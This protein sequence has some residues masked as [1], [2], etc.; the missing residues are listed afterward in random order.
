MDFL[1][2]LVLEILA[3]VLG[4]FIADLGLRSL[5]EALRGESSSSPG[6]ALLGYALFGVA[7]GGLSL[8]VLPEPLVHRESLRLAAL[9]IGPLVGGLAMAATGALLR[10]R[11]LRSLRVESFIY[12]FVLSLAIS[13]VRFLGTR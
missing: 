12:G 1:I 5:G 8:L 7:F 11:H 10:R 13:L 4:N 2:E 9:W 3:P 6:F